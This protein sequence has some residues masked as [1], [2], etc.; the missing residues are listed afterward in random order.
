MVSGLNFTRVYLI[1]VM[2]WIIFKRGEEEEEEGMGNH[3]SSHTHFHMF[4]SLLVYA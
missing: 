3:I 2:N 1:S 4:I